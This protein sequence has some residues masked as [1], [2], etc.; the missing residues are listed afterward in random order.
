MLNCGRTM[1]HQGGPGWHR[2]ETSISLTL[3]EHRELAGEITATVK[4]LRALCDLVVEVYGPGNRAAFSFVKAMEA[5]E[6]LEQDL[7]T[8]AVRDYPGYPAN[9]L[10][11]NGSAPA[12]GTQ[13]A[14]RIPLDAAG[15]VS[16]FLAETEGGKLR[17]E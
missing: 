5:L 11:L 16:A 1:R 9:G 3:E 15:L 8:Q 7:A 4:R 10:Y 17:K 12:G 14:P 13:E 6:H 2:T